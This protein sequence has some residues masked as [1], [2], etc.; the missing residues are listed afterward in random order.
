MS[1]HLFISVSHSQL[2]CALWSAFGLPQEFNLSLCL[3]YLCLSVSPWHNSRRR[4]LLILVLSHSNTHYS[5]GIWWGAGATKSWSS[6]VSLSCSCRI[7]WIG[8]QL[9]LNSLCYFVRTLTHV[10]V[11]SS[12][13]QIDACLHR[14][15]VSLKN[16]ESNRIFTLFLLIDL[17][18][19]SVLCICLPSEKNVH[20]N[21]DYH[22]L[23]LSKSDFSG[24]IR[25]LIKKI[26]LIMIK[27]TSWLEI[28]WFS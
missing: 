15:S 6:L 5:I 25:Y 17:L 18:E 23:A 24:K 4:S 21:R 3:L 20:N 27:N 14:M 11:H 13:F 26:G 10:V 8:C 19:R 16:W 22:W 1:I 28:R 9:P 7:S 2:R 12:W